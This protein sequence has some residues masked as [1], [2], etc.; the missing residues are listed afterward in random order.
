MS[1]II[2]KSNHP[3]E[4]KRINIQ[5]W[6]LRDEIEKAIALRLEESGGDSENLDIEDLRAFYSRKKPRYLDPDY[7]PDEDDDNV[8]AIGADGTDSS[9]N[10]RDDDALA[11]MAALQGGEEEGKS[12]DDAE[13]EDKEET[14]PEEE[15]EAAKLAAEMLGDQAGAGGEDEAAKLAAEML[16]D[17]AGADG[18]DEAAKLAAQ[19]LGDQADSGEDDKAPLTKAE[20]KRIHP[21]KDKLSKGFSLLSDL[22]MENIVFFSKQGYTFGQNITI[23]FLIPNRFMI[24]AEVKACAD[25]GRKSKIISET[26]PNYRVEADIT[27]LWDGERTNLRDFLKSVEPEIPPPPKKM[28]RPENDDEDDDEFEDLGF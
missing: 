8:V 17:Q 27:Y 14:A 23:E 10:E 1:T 9:G 15:D 5:I 22:N 18:D 6:K 24:S 11:M 3:V 21:D 4:V 13:S 20:L 26:K 12:T 16:G 25:L 28:K 2:N 19:M 7:D